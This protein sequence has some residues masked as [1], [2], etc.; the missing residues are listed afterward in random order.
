MQ[1]LE[2]ISTTL[3]VILV[4]AVGM[5]LRRVK[6]VGPGVV[7]GFKTLVVNLTLP[8]FSSIEIIWNSDLFSPVSWH[9]PCSQ[10][11]RAGR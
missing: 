4:V 3:P 9:A 5:G 1:F 10:N 2:T 8:G 7:A 6:L 11:P